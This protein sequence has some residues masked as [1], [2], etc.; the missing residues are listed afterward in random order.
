MVVSSQ[1]LSTEERE[2]LWIMFGTLWQKKYCSLDGQHGRPSINDCL[3][4][5][6]KTKHIK[7]SED[8]VDFLESYL[9]DMA[10]RCQ[11]GI[12]KGT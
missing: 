3:D 12:K 4:W 2:A 7:E 1:A 8:L 11:G 6:L 10:R 5:A 9:A